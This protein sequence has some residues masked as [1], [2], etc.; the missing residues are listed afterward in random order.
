M[1][2][3]QAIIQYLNQYD[4]MEEEHY[5]FGGV[6]ERDISLQIQV[7]PSNIS[8]QLRKLAEDGILETKYVPNLA[9]KGS[10]VVMYRIKD[11]NSTKEAQA[12]MQSLFK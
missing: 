3:K 11:F 7:K 4:Y 9:G 1:K 6:L 12:K 8:R 5:F 10:R 2:V